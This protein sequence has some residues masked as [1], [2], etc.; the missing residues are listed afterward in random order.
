MDRELVGV[1]VRIPL[2]GGCNTRLRRTGNVIHLMS[3][4]ILVD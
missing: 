1:C 2:A 3:L 4:V